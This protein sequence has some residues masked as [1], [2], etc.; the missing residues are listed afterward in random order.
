MMKIME[1]AATLLLVALVALTAPLWIELP[2]PTTAQITAQTM[3]Q[4][5]T[6]PAGQPTADRTVGGS[7]L[8]RSLT[9]PSGVL[10][11][12]PTS[13]DQADASVQ[14]WAT[15]CVK[16]PKA[17]GQLGD[18]TLQLDSA[19]NPHVVYGGDQLYHAWHDGAT[20]H[21]AVVEGSEHVSDF[22]ALALD[23]SDFPHIGYHEKGSRAVKYARWTGSAWETEIVVSGA[24]LRGFIGLVLDA[25][26]RPYMTYSDSA[27]HSLRYARWTGSFWETGIID[28]DV[29]YWQESGGGYSGFVP[30]S[31]AVSRS[32]SPA[33]AYFGHTQIKLARWVGDRW[34]GET[35]NFGSPDVSFPSTISLALDAFDRSHISYSSTGGQLWY[36]F[37]QGSY[38]VVVPVDA[39]GM[40]TSL[41][42]D[43]FNRRHIT[44][45]QLNDMTVKHAQAAEDL[46]AGWEIE[47]ISNIDSWGNTS[48]ALNG[49]GSPHVAFL[50]LRDG[51]K[52]LVYAQRAGAAWSVQQIDVNEPGIPAVLGSSAA[53]ALDAQH[54]PYVGYYD[55]SRRGA[56]VD[57]WNGAAWESAFTGANDIESVEA[58]AIDANRY[59]HIAYVDGWTPMVINYAYWQGEQWVIRQ[60]DQTSLDGWTISL[61]VDTS[62][63]A[64]LAYF[65]AP[66]VGLMYGIW[67]GSKWEV[68]SVDANARYYAAMALDSA[69]HPHIAYY[70]DAGNDIANLQYAQW[71][72]SAWHFETVDTAP[73]SYAYISLV[74]DATDQPHISYQDATR[75]TLKYAQRSGETWGIQIVDGPGAGWGTAIT[76]GRD[77]FPQIAYIR[78]GDRQ[79]CLAT[80]K[81]YGWERQTVTHIIGVDMRAFVLLVADADGRSHIVYE[82]QGV[83][84]AG[85]LPTLMLDKQATPANNVQ[86]G[87]VV[88]YTLALAGSG[89]DTTLWDSL[90]STLGFVNGS[91]SGTLTPTAT[92]NHAAHAI[93]WEGTLLTDTVHTVQFQAT[94]L[95]A[96]EVISMSTPIVNTAWLTDTTYQ[97]SVSSTFIIN[98]RRVYLPI[99]QR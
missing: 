46:S 50:D 65:G 61:A 76:I 28:N 1:M 16:C 29:F 60:V 22:V 2:P 98:P 32:G 99:L 52:S 9:S 21:Y 4:Q 74:L 41:A 90:P 19:G 51:Y 20:W 96:T 95:S 15:A 62:G 7:A 70:H 93:V 37:D 13:D 45:Y 77:G 81:G 78:P 40:F 71:T 43:P 63:R 10:P 14:G 53:L 47:T 97:R 48:L 42:L 57:R 85:S 54:T 6:T 30:H 35:M 86:A 5:S 25:S 84:H 64:H 68:R 24:D 91:L 83:R 79:V 31:L 23:G 17:F 82:D 66:D 69:G 72:G 27:D 80:W 59:P 73:G 49:A 18:R 55:H 88:T 75:W 8:E 58:L 26:D 56:Q 12:A 92:Y 87:D 44:Y 94:M 34:I 39:F 38:W 89:L 33:V 67:D 36:A 3:M 11:A